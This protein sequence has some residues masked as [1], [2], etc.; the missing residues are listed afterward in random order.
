[1]TG[2]V[3]LDTNI[4][5]YAA[6]QPD[7]RSETARGLLAQR[8]TISVQVL[9]EFA[10]VANRKLRRSWPEIARALA[11]IRVLCPPPLPVTAA[12]HEAALAIAG[13]TGYAIYD[14]LIIA[15]ALE[16]GCGILF[17]EDLQDGQLID[18]R[19]TVRNPF[20]KGIEATL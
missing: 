6:L 3:F 19:L 10:H 16:A 12:T 14:A 2:Q 20:G 4:L 15:S 5:V 17:S 7:P 11:A 8:G 18:G 9:N 13:R 1:M